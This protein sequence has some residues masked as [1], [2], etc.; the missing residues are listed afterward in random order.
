MS[1]TT[2][3]QGRFTATGS[4]VLIPL[5]AGITWMNTY[6]ITAMNDGSDLICTQAYW[7]FGMP[8]EAGILYT[9][10]N[11]TIDSN[12]PVYS[13]SNGFTYI[14]TSASTYG[15]VNATITAISTAAI[16]VATNSGTNGL[17]AGDVVRLF[18]VTN[19]RQLAG[20]DF[21][22]GQNTLS[23][24]TFSLD[25]MAQLPLAGTTGS[26]MKVDSNPIFYPNMRYI[27]SISKASQAV[28]EFTVTH[29]YK[30]GQ[31]IRFNVPSAFGMIEING[32]QGTIVAV[33]NTASVNTVTVDIDSSS[34][35]TFAFPTNAVAT[36]SAFTPATVVPVG[37]NTPVSLDEGV[38]ILS[39]ATVNTAELVMVLHGG[40]DAAGGA[41][42]DVIYWTAGTSF[43]VDNQ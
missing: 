3:L 43:S 29:G 23:T 5:R 1:N 32:L 21:T 37:Q 42:S 22:V 7:Q 20:Y 12:L 17:I 16:P 31:T 26:W 40:A 8:D 4:N 38:N 27:S 39:D 10:Y 33:S 9:N 25:Y 6:N 15:V 34:F 41:A 28:V 36:A 14:D 35:T 19:A 13:T 2:I 30:V 18:R 11:D 24:T